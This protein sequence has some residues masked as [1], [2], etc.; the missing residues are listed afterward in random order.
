MSLLERNDFNHQTDTS[1]P[2]EGFMNRS[3]TKEMADNSYMDNMKG[4]NYLKHFLGRKRADFSSPVQEFISGNYQFSS[5]LTLL[6]KPNL[7]LCFLQ[8]E[9]EMAFWWTSWEIKAKELG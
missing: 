7:S 2:A 3:Y 4:R 1:Y 8:E 9:G 5:H 6:F